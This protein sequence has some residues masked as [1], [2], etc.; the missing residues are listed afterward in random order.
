MASLLA[1][2]KPVKQ[3]QNLRGGSEAGKTKEYNPLAADRTH[4]PKA[5]VEIVQPGQQG[6]GNHAEQERQHDGEIDV[7]GGQEYHDYNIGQLE[8]RCAL[9][10]EGGGN[11][12][13]RFCEMRHRRSQ[14]Q[15]HVPTDHEDGNPQRNQL[16][17]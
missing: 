8:K 17:H 12:D 15:Y 3:M 11:I 6:K 14:Q 5:P 2:S 1:T 10:Q 4:V 13:T 9:T 7:T 16:N